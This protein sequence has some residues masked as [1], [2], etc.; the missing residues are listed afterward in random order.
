MRLVL[1]IMIHNIQSASWFLNRRYK[2]SF[3]CQFRILLDIFPVEYISSEY[4]SSLKL[5]GTAE[6]TFAGWTTSIV[7][8]T[9]F[10]FGIAK[11]FV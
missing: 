4:I 5:S 10:V 8:E 2:T 3:S 1:N 7:N 11:V 9:I 6:S